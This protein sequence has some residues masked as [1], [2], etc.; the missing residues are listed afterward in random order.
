MEITWCL[1]PS[2]ILLFYPPLSLP[3]LPYLIY[4]WSCCTHTHTSSQILSYNK[5]DIHK[6]NRV[7]AIG[8][9]RTSNRKLDISAGKSFISHLWN[10]T[11]KWFPTRVM[12]GRLLRSCESP[13]AASYTSSHSHLSFLHMLHSKLSGMRYWLT[14]KWLICITLW[15]FCSER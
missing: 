4:F 7:H 15:H 3:L 2:F 10:L 8:G 9:F 13:K 6:I 5:P 14:N 1:I 11:W 12:E